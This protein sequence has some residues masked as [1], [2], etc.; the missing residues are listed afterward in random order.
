MKSLDLL[1]ILCIFIKLSW[2]IQSDNTKI[3]YIFG[4]IPIDL[5][6]E[7]KK[8]ELENELKDADIS[9]N[10]TINNFSSYYNQLTKREK[11]YYNKIKEGS[12]KSPPEFEFTFI[13]DDTSEQLNIDEFNDKLRLLIPKIISII[14]FECPELWWIKTYQGS[15]NYCDGFKH[16]VIINTN[17][18]Y[19]VFYSYTIENFISINKKIEIAKNDIIQKVTELNLT[20]KYA[21]L[22]YLHDYLIVKNNYLKNDSIKHTR[23]IFG[24]LVENESVCVGYAKALQYLAQHFNIECIVAVSLTHEWNYVKMDDKWYIV[25][26]TWDDPFYFNDNIKSSGVN[27]NN[28]NNINNAFFLKGET[29]LDANDY[30]NNHKVVYSYFYGYDSISYPVISPD[31]YV[32]TEEEIKDAKKMKNLFPSSYLS[33]NIV[34]PNCGMEMDSSLVCPTTSSYCISGENR[35]YHSINSSCELEYSEDSNKNVVFMKNSTGYELYTSQKVNNTSEFMIYECN[36][37]DD[38]YYGCTTLPEDIYI[39]LTNQHIYI[40]DESK[41]QYYQLQNSIY[42]DNTNEKYYYCDYEGLCKENDN[43]EDFTLCKYIEEKLT[44]DIDK[45]EIFKCEENEDGYIDKL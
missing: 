22:L 1:L 39:D 30:G 23:T 7:E 12:K 8:N 26:L 31:D 44:I 32:P 24:S 2:S 42:P 33:T 34:L 10:G 18:S 25:D 20:S 41:Y 9:S 38:V 43:N 29:F 27:F 15:Y 6:S 40:Y 3:N 19:S 16:D 13:Y 4:D 5:L 37:I 11:E 36:V 28:P 14:K 17:P 35:I 21:I 45:G